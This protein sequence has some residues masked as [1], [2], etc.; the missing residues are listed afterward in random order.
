VFE[1]ALKW[2]TWPE[3]DRRDNYLL[4]KQIN[5]FCK[6]LLPFAIP[7][8]S[9]FGEAR[10]GGNSKKKQLS[11]FKKHQFSISNARLVCSKVAEG[12][13]SSLSEIDSWPIEDIWWYF[14]CEPKRQ[15]PFHFNLT[16][17]S[18]EN[19]VERNKERPYFGHTISFEYRELFTKWIAS[20]LVAEYSNDITPPPIL[21]SIE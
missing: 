2:G 4:L 16:F 14:G 11:G 17:I 7:P 10:F 21:L 15:A 12:N 20:M 3:Q 13:N 6:K 18:K 9:V 8:L 19:N 1:T 5:P